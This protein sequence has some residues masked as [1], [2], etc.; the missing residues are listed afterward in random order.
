MTTLKQILR[1]GLKVI[2]PEYSEEQINLLILPLLQ[3]NKL[4]LQQKQPLH[5]KI[6]N[7]FLNELIEELNQ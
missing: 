5:D 7:Q 6:C 2:F 4:W 3:A 1:E